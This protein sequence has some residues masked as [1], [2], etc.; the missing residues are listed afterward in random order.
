MVVECVR[1]PSW[2]GWGVCTCRHSDAQFS[3]DQR[4]RVLEE[5]LDFTL[6]TAMSPLFIEV[7]GC[8]VVV[9]AHLAPT[10]TKSWEV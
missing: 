4:V 2:S 8:R 9:M 10:V 6:G 7:E 3:R 5:E 1:M